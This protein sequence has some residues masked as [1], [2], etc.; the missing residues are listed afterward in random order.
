MLITHHHPHPRTTST[1]RV[2]H[3]STSIYAPP[4]GRGH[5]MS[6]YTVYSP[7]KDA[8]APV[9]A[10][11]YET[12]Q[13]LLCHGK[14]CEL[15]LSPVSNVPAAVCRPPRYWPDE[16]CRPPKH[17]RLQ[18]AVCLQCCRNVARSK[19]AL[20][21]HQIMARLP[22]R[23][24]TSIIQSSALVQ[25]SFSLSTPCTCTSVE[26]VISIKNLFRPFSPASFR[27]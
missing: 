14:C 11:A 10:R 16:L 25:G 26:E 20:N 7:Q 24:R 5:T 2:H 1:K 21:P 15:V 6:L 3:I 23:C 4:R 18:A 8:P 19:I 9:H 13:Q 27:R 17:P 12:A 22:P